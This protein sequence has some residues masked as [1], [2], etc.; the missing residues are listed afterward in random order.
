MLSYCV[1]LSEV[2]KDLC[3]EKGIEIDW[4]ALHKLSRPVDFVEQCS[5][6][7]EKVVNP[8]VTDLESLW[9]LIDSTPYISKVKIPTMFVSAKNDPVHNETT[10]PWE[11]IK[12]NENIVYVNTPR[13]GHLEFMVNYGR[14]RWYKNVMIKWFNAI[15]E[16]GNDHLL[17][18]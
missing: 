1:Q 16:L 13:G 11:E 5:Y 12:A 3:K 10:I 2:Y 17:I 4:D 14:Q 7:I 18:E 8:E 6:K 9:N 15:D